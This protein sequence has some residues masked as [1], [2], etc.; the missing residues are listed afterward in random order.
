MKNEP[1]GQF[2]E[3]RSSRCSPLRAALA[4]SLLC[5]VAATQGNNPAELR[6]FIDWQVGGIEKLM[7]PAENSDLPQ[8]R[9]PDGSI[10]PR[11]RITEAK[12]YL[13]KLLYFDPVRTARIIPEFGGDLSTKQT[14]SCGSCHLGEAGSKAGTLLN[15]GVG[16]EGRG[17]TDDEGDFIPRRRI[18]P[19]LVDMLTTLTEICASNPNENC[20]GGPAEPDLIASGTADAVDSVGRNA[21]TMIGFAFNN[22]L[23]QGGLAGD[24]SPFGINPTGK[25]AGENL[26]A[27]TISVH[28]MAEFQ[29]AELQAVAA[30]RRLFAEAFPEEAAQAEAQGDLDL[31]INDDTVGR[32]LATFLRTVVTRNT[33]WDRFLAGDNDALTS[34]QRRGARLFFTE[35]TDVR[36]DDERG[37]GCF[38]CHSGPMLNKQ[39]GDEAGLLVEE[40]FFNLGLGDHPLVA[41]NRLAL[42]NP[43]L[44]DTGRLEVTHRL[45]DAFEFRVLSLRQLR[46]GRL[47]MH[48]G[49]FTRIKDVVEYFNDGKPQDEEAAD[50]GTL[51]PRFTHPRGPGSRRGLGLSDEDVDDIYYF[52]KNALYDPA[53][54]HFDPDSTTDTFDPNERDLTYSVHRPDL[55]ALGATD[56]LMPSGRPRSNDDALSRRDLGLEFLDVT[57]QVD[58]RLTDSDT[59]SGGRRREDTYRIRNDS[60]STVDTHLLLVAQGLPDEIR[61]E[62]ASGITSTG[63]P[64]LRVFLPRGVLLPGKSIEETLCFERE[65]DGPSVSYTLIL[66]SG[67]GNP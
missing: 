33:P 58:I 38:T 27:G 43:L 7:V 37:A 32:A 35:A 21:P 20:F 40:N 66:L 19:G 2:A 61:L 23:L 3:R 47:F 11:F 67:Q 41:L 14:A 59:R 31:L 10:D 63:D 44:R 55:A 54:V 26:T 30:Y 28:R 4:V 12:R 18:Q 50:A 29:A 65:S 51:S 22:R 36:D 34:S 48:N 17:Y 13:G 49:S 60:S 5:G 57:A 25:P 62:N 6:R 1:K 24:P 53:F 9:L 45:E 42:N 16:G 39:L 52:L 15:F 64:Y 8:P 46:D 56:G